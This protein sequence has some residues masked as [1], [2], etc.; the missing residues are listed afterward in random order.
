[1]ILKK[2]SVAVSW[3][4]RVSHTS[5]IQNSSEEQQLPNKMLWF[6]A[7]WY[8][9]YSCLHY[10]P[11]LKTVLYFE[12]VK[13]YTIIKTTLKKKNDPAFCTKGFSNWKNATGR[14]SGCSYCLNRHKDYHEKC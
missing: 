3:T 10:S 1:M 9:Q 6:Q 13:A 4:W 8:S 7:N 11:T 5:L 12:C 2:V 14:F